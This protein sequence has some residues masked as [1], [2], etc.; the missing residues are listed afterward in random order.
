MEP[1][2]I[3]NEMP[4]T[5]GNGRQPALL[6]APEKAAVILALLGPENAGPVVEKIKDEHLRAFMYTLENL[7]LIPRESMLSAVADFIT[8]LEERRGGFRGGTAAARELAESLFETDRAAQLFGKASGTKPENASSEATWAELRIRKVPDI[9]AYLASQKSAV[10]SIVLSQFSSEVA[11]EILSELPE[12]LSVSCVRQMSRGEKIDDRT[13]AAV[14]ELIQSEFLATAEA[15]DEGGA[16]DF[17]S[18]ILG[19]L[20]KDR[21]DMMLG[22]L[23]KADP[24]QAKLIRKRMLTFED[25]P[26]RLPT[27]AIPIIFKDCDPEMLLKALKAGQDQE[28]A[29]VE[30]LYAN[31]SQRMAGQYKEQVEE[32]GGISQKEADNAIATLMGFISRLEKEGRVT[33]IKPVSEDAAVP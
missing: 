14:A 18:E 5:L 24:E 26:K 17:V 2:P 19:I 13:L 3:L 15:E 23:D 12:Q 20:P 6:R 4:S 1:L 32:L 27:T 28:P 29:T 21:R 31:I 30:F 11:S 9:A 16:V 25:L 22:S 8:E 33:L 7:K 10:I